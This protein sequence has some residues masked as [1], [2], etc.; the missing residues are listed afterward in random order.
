[1]ALRDKYL[2]WLEIHGEEGVDCSWSCRYFGDG[3]PEEGMKPTD[4][5]RREEE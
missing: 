3:L 4:Y 1:M 2:D 5:W